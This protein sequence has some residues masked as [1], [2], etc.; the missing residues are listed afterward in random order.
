MPSSLLSSTLLLISTSPGAAQY[1][2]GTGS[3]DA[4]EWITALNDAKVQWDP[5]PTRQD[6]SMLYSSN[7]NALVE[8]P[9]WGDW[10]T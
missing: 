1:F 2:S 10:W 8:G 4:G 9:T 7:W 6:V 3:G 5:C